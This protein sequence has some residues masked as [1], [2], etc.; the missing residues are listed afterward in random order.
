MLKFPQVTLGSKVKGKTVSQTVKT[1]MC[2]E[3]PRDGTMKESRMYMV[4]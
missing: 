4:T 1:L 3:Q 2:M